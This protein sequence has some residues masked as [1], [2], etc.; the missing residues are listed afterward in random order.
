MFACRQRDAFERT[1]LAEKN[2]R[3]EKRSIDAQIACKPLQVNGVLQNGIEE[4]L[5]VGLS[6]HGER[7]RPV[8]LRFRSEN[9]TAVVLGF[10]NVNPGFV[11]QDDVDF[12]LF[13]TG[14]RH[15][16]IEQK[17]LV[18]GQIPKGAPREIFSAQAEVEKDLEK[19]VS[20]SAC[21]TLSSHR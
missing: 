20:R 2:V 11:Q 14:F 18:S 12:R 6:P 19:S 5:L 17:P 8:F 16:A 3:I 9:P 13:L 4:M 15:I 21:N 1:A 10:K 7:L